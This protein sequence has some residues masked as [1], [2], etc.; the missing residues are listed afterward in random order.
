MAFLHLQVFRY[1]GMFDVQAGFEIAP[2]YR[3]SMEGEVGG[4]II[5]TKKWYYKP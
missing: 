2:C 3:Y 1:L 5:A 4:K